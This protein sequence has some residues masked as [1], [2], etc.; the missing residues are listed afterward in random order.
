ML[1]EKVEL[2]SNIKPEPKEEVIESLL[3]KGKPLKLDDEEQKKVVKAFKEEFEA[4]KTERMDIDGEDFDSFLASMDRQRKGQMPKTAN[5]AYNLDTGLTK[6][7]C[8]DIVRTTINAIFDVDP[9]ISVNPRPGFAKGVGTKVCKEQQEFLDYVI[10]EKIPLRKSLRLAA[11]SATYKKV[12]VIKWVHKVRK[13]KRIGHAKFEGKPEV[14]G[15]NQQTGQPLIKNKALEDF[16][17]NYGDMIRKEEER[18]PGS[19][20]YDW[21]INRLKEGKKVEFDY[22]YDDVVYNDPYPQFVD[23]KNFYVRKD[24]DGYWGLCEAQLIA[25]RISF[26]YYQLKNLEK[27]YDF[28]NLDKL[29]YDNEEDK[30]ADNKR[31]NYA[32]ENYNIIECPFYV[33][34]PDEE[35]YTKV[36]LWIAEE[37]MVYLGGIYYPYT[38]LDSYYVPHYVKCTDNGFYQEGVAE[39]V[40]DTHLSKN[41]I[42]NHTLE[43]AQ[44]AN[45]IVPIADKNSDIVKQFLNNTWINGMPLYGNAKDIDFLNNKIKLPDIS[46]L[47]VL[48]QTLTRVASE[49]TRVSDLR[50]GKETPLDPNAP[51]N[52]TAMLL[53]ESGRG[54][55]DYVD[56]FINGFNIDAQ[57]ILKLYYEMNQDEQE[58]LERRQKAVTG[59]EPKKISKASM[60]ARTSIQ[61]QAM[62][63][64][65]NKI[66]AKREDLA[67]NQFLTNEMIVISNPEANYERIKIVM[68]GWSPKWK[69]AI[70]KILP[71][72]EEFKAQQAAIALQAVQQYVQVKIQESKMTGQPPNMVPEELIGMMSQMQAL[73]TMPAK[74][75]Q[76]IKK[77]QSKGAK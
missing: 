31:E 27:E 25:E 58:Y 8:S 63:Y 72:L 36:V 16:M 2:K 46:G 1:K 11:N 21:I 74:Q 64:D 43:A 30:K 42:L 35:E 59:K 73:A 40:T 13:E 71:P 20:K 69:N 66:N 57:V 47:L 49:L 56:E 32:T 5:R 70:N 68:A 44:M 19:K 22:E 41:A 55:K 3:S 34:L 6:I 53:Q 4:I 10:D 23:N 50:S 65:F 28:V 24:T 14:I 48:D 60:I 39:D 76:E 12:G 77:S 29:I 33:R 61:S 15:I 67:I 54:V 51:G 37:K 75:S 9:I 52:K 7:K 26:S 17:L 45:T 18:N 38:V 62:A